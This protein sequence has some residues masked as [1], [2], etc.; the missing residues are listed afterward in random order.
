MANRLVLILT[1]LLVSS[2]SERDGGVNVETPII[3]PAPIHLDAESIQ[4]KN[5]RAFCATIRPTLTLVVLLD[6]DAKKARSLVVEN[7]VPQDSVSLS[8]ES[9]NLSSDQKS[10]TVDGDSNYY[11]FTSVT[12]DQL[13]SGQPAPTLNE[14]AN[15]RALSLRGDLVPHVEV[16]YAVIEGSR[17][18]GYAVS[19]SMA[20]GG[21]KKIPPSQSHYGYSDSFTQNLYLS[22]GM[23]LLTDAKFFIYAYSTINDSNGLKYTGIEVT[24]CEGDKRYIY[25]QDHNTGVVTL[26]ELLRAN[27]PDHWT[28]NCP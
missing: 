14:I 12:V 2:C 11:A 6:L 21:G 24:P 5:E 13:V 26:K 1:F 27:G 23:S 9:V 4:G 19:S 20:M 10:L 22:L 18:V 17:S 8:F 28:N 25:H 16:V 15:I 7:N 3:G